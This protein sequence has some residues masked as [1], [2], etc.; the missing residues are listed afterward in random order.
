MKEDRITKITKNKGYTLM[1]L[2]VVVGVMAVILG[3]GMR[4][5]YQSLRSSSRVDFEL[6]MD[7]S[8]R[9][10]EGSMMDVIS[11]GKVTELS[12]QDQVACLSAGVTGVT[13]ERLSV[14]VD[15]KETEFF[16]DDDDIASRSVDPVNQLKV[17][18]VGI[19]VN[20]LG[21]TWVCL[22]GQHESL[23]IDIG[24]QAEKE[25][26]AVPV[27]KDYSFEILLKNSGYY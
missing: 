7:S 22:S 19:Q 1:E 13:G 10:I 17:N 18:P 25:D 9:V 3:A 6:F 15:G 12:G 21:F 11:F 26:Q 4:V 5:F 24:A 27:E 20:S 23:V 8:S 16:L 2:V 14:T